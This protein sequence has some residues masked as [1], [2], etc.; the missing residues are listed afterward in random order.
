M[1]A[2]DRK[3][4]INKAWPNTSTN[5]NIGT[6]AFVDDAYPIFNWITEVP[7]FNSYLAYDT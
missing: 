7:K 3:Q 2:G 1:R 4:G 6:P 5:S